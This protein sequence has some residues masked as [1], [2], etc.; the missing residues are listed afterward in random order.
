VLVLAL[1]G[2]TM[3]I[4][5]S[6][7]VSDSDDSDD[8]GDNMDELCAVTKS[9]IVLLYHL[10]FLEYEQH[11]FCHQEA[12]KQILFPPEH[13]H[14]P[15]QAKAKF[16]NGEAFLFIKKAYFGTPGDLTTPIFKD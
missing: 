11:Q 1:L 6:N 15:R 8:V 10:C 2:N 5:N 9:V 3:D 16:E 4:E 7:F 13:R 14:L 12:V